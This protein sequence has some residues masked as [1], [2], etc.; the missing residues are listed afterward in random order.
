MDI[1]VSWWVWYTS[2]LPDCLESAIWII[3]ISMNSIK[4]VS[5]NHFLI[6]FFKLNFKCSM[7]MQT[8]QKAVNAVQL[9]LSKLFIICRRSSKHHREALLYIWWYLCFILPFARFLGNLF[10]KW[11]LTKTSLTC[12]SK[13]CRCYYC[14][15]KITCQG[16]YCSCFSTWYIK[17]ASSFRS[18]CCDVFYETLFLDLGKLDVA[19]I[20][21]QQFLVSLS[22]K[23]L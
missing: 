8:K 18:V 23:Y 22:G 17:V 6:L 4:F 21:S 3:I 11:E 20:Y 19:Q 16:L 5:G 13:V 15:T 1:I 12:L 9:L 10:K 14:V 7:Y 2:F